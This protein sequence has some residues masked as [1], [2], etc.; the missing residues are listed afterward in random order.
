MTS[1]DLI[2]RKTS[3]S[4]LKLKMS[5]KSYLFFINGMIFRNNSS[6]LWGFT[7]TGG[8]FISGAS[9]F[10]NVSCMYWLQS[11]LGKKIN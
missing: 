6:T 11:L 7:D 5:S 2:S 9:N 4:V 10:I 3:K 1:Y 8:S